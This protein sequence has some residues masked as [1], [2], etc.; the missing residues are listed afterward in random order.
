MHRVEADQCDLLYGLLDIIKRGLQRSFLVGKQPIRQVI[1]FRPALLRYPL[2][3]RGRDPVVS[4]Y[5]S[6]RFGCIALRVKL[7]FTGHSLKSL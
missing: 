1:T 3:M 4:F 2:F 7:N 6:C 5:H